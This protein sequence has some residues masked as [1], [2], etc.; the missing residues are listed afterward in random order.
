M[1]GV[2]ICNFPNPSAKCSEIIKGK[3]NKNTEMFFTPD[4]YEKNKY[5]RQA[6]KSG[7]RNNNNKEQC[8]IHIHIQV[9]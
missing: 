8:L 6:R 7:K 9:L 3:P 5:T 1:V 2:I 4:K